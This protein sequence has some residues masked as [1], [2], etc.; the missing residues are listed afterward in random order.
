MDIREKL[1]LMRFDKITTL[2]LDEENRINRKFVRK[3][4]IADCIYMFVVENRILYIGK[5]NCL[6]KRF[7]TY[8]NSAYWKGAFRNNVK[9]TKILEKQIRKNKMVDVYVKRCEHYYHQEEKS[10]I[11]FFKPVLNKLEVNYYVKN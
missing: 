10:L 1:H 2:E 4:E 8:R 9:K 6:W 3:N 7:D 5:T 11:R